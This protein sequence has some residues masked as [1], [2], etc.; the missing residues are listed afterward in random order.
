M[1]ITGSTVVCN[2]SLCRVSAASALPAHAHISTMA[3]LC[4]TVCQQPNKT[5]R[6]RVLG[7][8]LVRSSLHTARHGKLASGDSRLDV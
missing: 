6:C 7:Q 1:C 2:Q 3:Y 5:T 4:I 8:P